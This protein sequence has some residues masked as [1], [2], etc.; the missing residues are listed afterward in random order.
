[1]SICPSELSGCSSAKGAKRQKAAESILGRTVMMRILGFALFLL[2]YKRSEIAEV[3]GTDLNTFLSFL[4]RIGKVGVDA[5]RDRRRKA[6]LSVSQAEEISIRAGKATD[7]DVIIETNRD[8]QLMRIP[9]KNVVQQK[10][11]LLSLGLDNH[12]KPAEI[13]EILDCTP[14]YVSVL[15]KKLE[16]GDV[17]AIVDKRVGQATEYRVTEDVKGELIVQWAA[18]SV[19]GRKTSSPVLAEALTERCDLSIPERTVREHL[20]KLGLGKLSPALFSLVEKIKKG[21][22]D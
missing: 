7:G 15:E 6:D 3:T 22:A 4:T 20:K 8:Q 18:N 1:M 19:T 16:A 13:A 2:G 10:I 17:P 12:L 9:A 5:F 14:G 11:I 21:S